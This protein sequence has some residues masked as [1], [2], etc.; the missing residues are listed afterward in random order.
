VVADGSTGPA[1]SAAMT[2]VAAGDELAF[3]VRTDTLEELWSSAI[4]IRI[5]L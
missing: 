3:D 2:S 5:G 1:A 4:R